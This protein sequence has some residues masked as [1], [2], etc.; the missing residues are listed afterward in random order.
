[1]DPMQTER[2]RARNI[3]RR[4][5]V[6][7]PVDQ[8]IQYGAL[9]IDRPPE[10]MMLTPDRQKHFVHVPLITGPRPSTSQLIGILLA[11][12]ATPFPDAS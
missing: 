7:D 11:K 10:I 3:I 9:L 6:R 2:E 8:N 4:H 1:M 5:R 12:L